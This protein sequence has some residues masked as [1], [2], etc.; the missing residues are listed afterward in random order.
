VALI[1]TWS[2]DTLRIGV[3]AFCRLSLAFRADVASAIHPDRWVAFTALRLATDLTDILVVIA[4]FAK[5]RHL[6]KPPQVPPH[7]IRAIHRQSDR[8]EALRTKGKEG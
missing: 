5:I 1:A 8:L 6:E 7:K 4:A 2:S 3:S